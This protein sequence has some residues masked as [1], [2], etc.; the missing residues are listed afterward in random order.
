MQNYFRK[1]ILLNLLSVSA[2][3]FYYLFF[4]FLKKNTFIINENEYYAAQITLLESCI[5]YFCVGLI[6][7]I[8]SFIEVYFIKNY[9]LYNNIEIKLPNIIK[10]IHKYVFYGGLVIFFIPVYYFIFSVIFGWLI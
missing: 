8:L 1:S 9:R 7:I 2:Y 5:T 4:Y 3:I 6:A 10:N